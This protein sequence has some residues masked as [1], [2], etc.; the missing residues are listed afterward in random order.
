MLLNYHDDILK[1]S[2]DNEKDYFNSLKEFRYISKS[3]L[4]NGLHYLDVPCNDIVY[5][6]NN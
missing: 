3:L 5:T 4:N 2:F 6:N 1:T